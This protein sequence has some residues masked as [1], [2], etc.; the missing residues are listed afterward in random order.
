M[1]ARPPPPPDRPETVSQVSAPDLEER[2]RLDRACVARVLAG[3]RNAYGLLV[4]RH[5]SRV[6]HLARSLVRNQADAT[7]IAQ[8]C[9]VR[10][11]ANL[12]S[13]RAEGSF[14]AWIARIANN[15]AI[16]F[17]RRQ[18][19]Q[20]PTEFDEALG[21]SDGEEARSGLL[22]G[23]LGGDPQAN[24]LRH[25]LGEV[26]EAALARLPQKHRAILVLREMDGLSYEEIAQVLEIPIGTVMSRLFHARAKMQALLATYVA[27][28]GALAGTAESTEDLNAPAA[29]TSRK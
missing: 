16:D 23:R 4:E 6:Y 26:L 13:Y 7:D 28:S 22:S 18:K 20:A 14:T 2:D 17:L 29:R 24:A 11:Y 10:A 19:T 9:F 8:E 1:T 3:D 15:L 12:R 25:E 5:Q 27:D 21:Q